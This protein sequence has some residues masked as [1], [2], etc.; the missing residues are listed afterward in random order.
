MIALFIETEPFA[1]E[2]RGRDLNAR[3]EFEAI[4]VALWTLPLHGSRQ[5]RNLEPGQLRIRGIM[6][7]TVA[8][9]IFIIGIIINFIFVV[10]VVVVVVVV[11]IVVFVDLT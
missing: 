3:N 2:S 7:I 4:R 1:P 11:F 6:D 5:R 9:F 8:I 10:V